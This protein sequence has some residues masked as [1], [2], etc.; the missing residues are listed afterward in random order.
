M[1]RS[2]FAERQY[3]TVFHLELGSSRGG[4]FVPTQPL[5]WHLGFDAAT[6]ARDAHRIWRL[7]NV[8][9]PRG[10]S[11]SPFLWPRLPRRY[12]AAISARAVSLFIQFKVPKH[13]DGLKAKYRLQFGIPYYEVT[14]VR[15]QQNKLADLQRRVQSRALVRYASPAFWKRVDFD[16]FATK[17]RVLSQ[18]A[19]LIP[20]RVGNHKKWMYAGPSGK[21][22]L[23]PDPEEVDSESWETLIA[24]LGEQ[25]Q[26][27]SLRK[28]VS[29]LAQSLR[30]SQA[31]ELAYRDAAWLAAIRDYARLAHEDERYLID[32]RTIADAAEQA[33]ASWLVLLFL[34]PA[35]RRIIEM[36][37]E[38][39]WSQY[40]Y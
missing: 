35:S 33:N 6:N 13:Q 37:Q 23:N 31:S 18:S 40:W 1:K 19:Y 11:L 24:L 39:L 8:S 32:V 15:D 38:F 26:L 10:I 14:I 21:V 22:I 3:E 12:H 2:E 7:L 28:H 30:E 9:A 5:E 34:D 17:R 27:E 4:P 20:S 36:F 16:D 25:A 29:A